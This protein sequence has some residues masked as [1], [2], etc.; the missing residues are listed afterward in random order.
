MFRRSATLFLALMATTFSVSAIAQDRKP[1]LTE[2][3]AVEKSAPAPSTVKPAGEHSLLE[4]LRWSY[5]NNPSIRATRA[6]LLAA[7]ERLPQAQAGWKP[8]ANASADITRTDVDTDGGDAESTSKSVGVQIRQPVYRGGRTVS[9]IDSA[10]NAIMAQRAFLMATEQDVLLQAVTAYM[11]VLRDQSLYDLSINNKDVI[12]KQLDASQARFDAGDVTRTDVSQSQARLAL[13]DATRVSSLGDLRGSLAVFEQVTGLPPTGLV[14][15]EVKIPL[16]QTLDE[17]VAMAEQ[18]NPSVLAARFLQNAAEEDIDTVFGELLPDVGLFGTIDHTRDPYPGIDDR[19]TVTTFGISAVIPLYEAGSVRSRVRAAKST[20]IQRR[21]EVSEATR[22]A[23]QETVSSWEDLQAARSEIV[24][25]RAQVDASRIARD[26]VH[27]EAELGTRTILDALNA[28]QELLDAESAL[29]TAQRNEVVASFSLAA[30][31]GL[32]TPDI[33]GFPELK[34][35]YNVHVDEI[36][37]KIFSTSTDF[38]QDRL[39][40]NGDESG[41][42]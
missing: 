18:Y 8:T 38:G 34:Q 17:A 1:L 22:L 5:D 27:K 31:L 4:V 10:K 24:S 32:M 35:D 37:H 33:L 20:A 36:T 12:S 21:I 3:L 7:Q 39:E 26:G 40:K 28:D 19:E 2:P 6:A 9:G 16:P 11:N 23:R 41:V 30:N 14:F 29:V 42:N 13:A 25:R 15:P